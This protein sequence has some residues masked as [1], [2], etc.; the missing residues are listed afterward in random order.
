MIFWGGQKASGCEFKTEEGQKKAWGGGGGGKRGPDRGQGGQEEG[1]GWGAKSAM[2]WAVVTS[3]SLWGHTSHGSHTS[4]KEP[5]REEGV[6][7]RVCV[8]P[9]SVCV[10]ACARACACAR[11]HVRACVCVCMYACM[12]VCVC[13]GQGGGGGEG[14]VSWMRGQGHS[15]ACSITVSHYP[16][17]WPI[18]HHPHPLFPPNAPPARH[19][20]NPRP[21]RRRVGG[22]HS[23]TV[24]VM[25]RA[26]MH[27]TPGVLAYWPVADRTGKSE[28][29]SNA[30]WG[31]GTCMHGPI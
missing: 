25:L 3:L 6:C 21:G 14:K 24:R 10:C 4:W 7:V 2:G 8:C 13:E 27:K 26:N 9:A 19:S 5:E 29:K 11:V 12:H 17:D 1:G 18:T 30:G 28:P 31:G 23:C 20:W 16:S 15:N 22:R